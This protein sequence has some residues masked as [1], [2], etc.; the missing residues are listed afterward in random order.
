MSNDLFEKF[1]KTIEPMESQIDSLIFQFE[2]L[3]K[4]KMPDQNSFHGQLHEFF[5]RTPSAGRYCIEIRNQ[6]YLNKK[7]FDFLKAQN[8]AH[9]FLH[10]YWM[11]SIFSLYEKHKNDIEKFTVIRLH[12]PDRS[13]IEKKAKNNWNKILEPKDNELDLLKGMITDLIERKIKVTISVNNHYEGSAPLTIDRLL[14]LF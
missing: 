10:G 7:Y 4:Q 13:D 14:R 2:Y 6:N 1:L 5:E 11:P 3:N 8:V 9:V 12:G